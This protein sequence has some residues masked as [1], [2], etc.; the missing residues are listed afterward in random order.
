MQKESEVIQDNGLAFHHMQSGHEFDFNNTEIRRTDKDYYRRLIL[1]G[2]EIKFADN[3]VNLQAGFQID[4]C[5]TPFLG[6][7]IQAKI[8]RVN[9]MMHEEFRSVKIRIFSC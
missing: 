5:W 1:E 2:I 7:C 8:V 9:R 3:L 6:S 4:E